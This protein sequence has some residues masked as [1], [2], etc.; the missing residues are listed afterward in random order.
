MV[1]LAVKDGGQIRLLHLI[2]RD[3]PTHLA[4]RSTETRVAE[5]SIGRAG[6][7]AKGLM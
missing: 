4:T 5:H 6:V 3:F 1:D 2:T 7:A